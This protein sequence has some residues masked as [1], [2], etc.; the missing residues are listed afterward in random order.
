MAR[1]NLIEYPYFNETFKI[2]TND[3]AFQLGA[4]ISQKGKPIA[5]YRRKLTDDQ[6][7][8]IVREKEILSIIEILRELGKIVL[9]QKMRIYT[10]K[11]LYL[12]KKIQK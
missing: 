2:H 4:I 3:S 7:Q 10:D 1:D 11:K 12:F 6:Q 9:G 5:F 8:Y